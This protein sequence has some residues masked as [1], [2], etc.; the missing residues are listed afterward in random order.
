MA[1]HNFQLYLHMNRAVAR[2]EATVEYTHHQGL[3]AN[4]GAP[5][6]NPPEPAQCEF[7]SLQLDGKRVPLDT[8][9]RSILDAVELEILDTFGLL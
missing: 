6:V 7:L 1:L 8:I 9:P 5:P 3:S 2:L 4:G